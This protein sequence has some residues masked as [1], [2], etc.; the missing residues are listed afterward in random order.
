MANNVHK[1]IDGLGSGFF[2]EKLGVSAHAV[3]SAKSKR[4]LPGLW[5]GV[6][7]PACVERGIP[8]CLNDFNWRSAD[9]KLGNMPKT[10]GV[11]ESSQGQGNKTLKSEDDAP[12]AQGASFDPDPIEI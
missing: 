2:Q 6:V 3:R 11:G 4:L 9:K 10:Y 7:A 5:Y 1:I 12:H 8:I